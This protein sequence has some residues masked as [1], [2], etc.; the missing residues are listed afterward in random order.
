MHKFHYFGTCRVHAPLVHLA[1]NNNIELLENNWSFLHT[2]KEILQAINLVKG[3]K[4]IPKELKTVAGFPKGVYG[5][6]LNEADFFVVEVSSLKS[7]ML[8][9]TFM[10]LNRLREKTVVPFP[11]LNLWFKTLEKAGKSEHI[12]GVGDS[13]IDYFIDNSRCKKLH[14]SEI[15]ADLIEIFDLLGKPVILVSSFNYPDK[16]TGEFLIPRLELIKILSDFNHSN[17]LKFIDPSVLLE[18][19]GYHKSIKDSA[20]YTDS[21]IPKVSQHIW[22]ELNSVRGFRDA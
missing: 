16:N 1:K 20:H 3:N 17:L 6:D 5:I 8:D 4:S 2:T 14:D 21:M 7:F 15:H 13:T 22:C 10:Q 11:E 19:E 12:G 9:S 18:S